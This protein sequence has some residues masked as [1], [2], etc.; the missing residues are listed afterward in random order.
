[1][2]ITQIY[3]CSCRGHEKIGKIGEV[4]QKENE[5]ASDFFFLDRLRPVFR[6]HSGMDYNEDIMNA[7]LNGLLSAV[8]SHV[9]KNIR[10][11]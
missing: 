2:I 5:T 11:Q 4:K 8:K 1:M 9:G 7:F 10:S 6:Q 3:S